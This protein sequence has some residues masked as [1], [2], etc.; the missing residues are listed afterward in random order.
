METISINLV[1]LK[2]DAYEI[3]HR[4]RAASVTPSKGGILQ[5]LFL[6]KFENK[7]SRSVRQNIETIKVRQSRSN[8]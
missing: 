7:F 6:L 5:Y 2:L 8:P 1:Y 4:N 3:S